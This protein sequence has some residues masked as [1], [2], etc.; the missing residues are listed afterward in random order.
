MLIILIEIFGILG[1]Y[2]LL[3]MYNAIATDF[4]I[5]SVS[6]MLYIV[7]LFPLMI[8]LNELNKLINFFNLEGLLFFQII[9][10]FSYLICGFVGLYL[11][12]MLFILCFYG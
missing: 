12:V 3:F 11:F 8:L 9:F 4:L 10:R 6:L 5:D 7:F 2:V 1:F